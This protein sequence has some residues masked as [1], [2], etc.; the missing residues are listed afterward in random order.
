MNFIIKKQFVNNLD[1]CFISSLHCNRGLALPLEDKE[2][3]ILL[4]VQC[5]GLLVV[6]D[7]HCHIHI[8]ECEE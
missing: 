4:A 5:T 7:K 6:S 8:A 2:L 1:Y 3:T